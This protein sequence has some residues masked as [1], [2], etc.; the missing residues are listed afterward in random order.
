[1]V[2][3]VL[4]MHVPQAPDP[5]EL[6][7]DPSL[8]EHIAHVIAE[9]GF[10]GDAT[11]AL[12]AYVALTSR[13]RRWPLC[14][15]YVAQSGAGKS[16]AVE[17]AQALMPESAYVEFDATSPAVFA[18]HERDDADVYRNK[19]ILFSEADSIPDKGPIASA[20]RTLLSKGNASY[21][22]VESA[23]NG[24]GP[25]TAVK[26]PR[27][28]PSGL[29]TTGIK[30]LAPQLATRALELAI[31]DDPVLTKQIMLKQAQLAKQGGS[32]P[33]DLEQFLEVQ[34][35]LELH[36]ERR[37]VLPFA[38]ELA[39]LTSAGDTRMRRDFRQLLVTIE[40]VA[41][42]HQCQRDTDA[43]GAVEATYADYAIA[44]RLLAP[45]F[46]AI[47]EEGVTPA[48]REAINE[49]KRDEDVSLATLCARLGVKKTAGWERADKAKKAG[50]LENVEPRPQH[51]AI[52]RR[53]ERP[54]SDTTTNL[55]TVEQLRQACECSGH[56]PN[57]H[58]N[59]L[60]TVA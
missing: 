11:P 46:E 43:V 51:P 13:L 38:S 21:E 58:P 14:L 39:T 35:W 49:V 27:R 7:R 17:A 24:K 60:R 42:L 53:T 54:L 52:Y 59:R 10:A 44:R 28:G 16:A 5:P 40:T 36:G 33:V 4:P 8:F 50:Y 45:I 56:G 29:I 23:G 34:R 15:S 1:M 57:S 9:R 6:L 32:A 31:S 25:L 48:V 18:Y 37:V 20:I 22:V 19:I 41:M 3:T 2:A 12:L 55:P 47:E 30:S 26:I